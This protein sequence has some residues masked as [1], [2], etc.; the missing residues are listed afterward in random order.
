MLR[1][2]DRLL[3]PEE[4]AL[5]ILLMTQGNPYGGLGESNRQATTRLNNAGR[6]VLS[7]QSDTRVV[8][9]I[10]SIDPFW[11]GNEGSPALDPKSLAQHSR[12]CFRIDAVLLPENAL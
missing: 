11:P 8:A 1:Y 10:F 6:I 4:V 9:I 2:S 3:G 7:R 5:L 12:N